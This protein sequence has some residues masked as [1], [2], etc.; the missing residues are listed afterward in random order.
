MSMEKQEKGLELETCLCCTVAEKTNRV[1]KE[2]WDLVPNSETEKRLVRNS[3]T[4]NK[5]T[6][7]V[8][9][10]RRETEQPVT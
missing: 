1:Q 2:P 10:Q 9:Q 7:L 3:E 4:E 8:R 6:F 5:I